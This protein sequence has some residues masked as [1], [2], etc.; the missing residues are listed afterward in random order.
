MPCPC[1]ASKDP[2]TFPCLSKWIMDG[3]RTQQSATPISAS[4]S[5]SVRSFG[6]F[7]TQTLSSLSTASP[8]TPPSFHLF[9]NGFG[10]SGSNLNFGAVSVC[11]PI[12]AQKKMKANA[13]T[14]DTPRIKGPPFGIVLLDSA[15]I[16][17]R[18]VR[19]G[20]PFELAG[21]NLDICQLRWVVR[22][23]SPREGVDVQDVEARKD[24]FFSLYEAQLRSAGAKHVVHFELYEGNRLVHAI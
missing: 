14:S 5:I 10:Q 21:A 13:A 7:S 4:N 20:P 12:P 8:V 18:P 15:P 2:I 11:A 1:G 17:C 6:R 9:G 22:N 24:F 23:G 16:V 19:Y 3:G